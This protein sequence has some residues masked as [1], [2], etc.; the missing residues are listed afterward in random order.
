MNTHIHILYTRAHNHSDTQLINSPVH[1]QTHVHELMCL[2]TRKQRYTYT[3]TRLDN[4]T[5]TNT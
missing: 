5:N 3:N 1:T 4:L 2:F